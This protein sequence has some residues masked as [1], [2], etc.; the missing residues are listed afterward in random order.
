MIWGG[1]SA[2]GMTELAILDGKQDS[3]KYIFTLCEYL[4]PFAHHLYGCDFV[5]QQD[6]VS[7]HT[8]NVSIAF[9]E[10]M[11][12][13]VMNWPAKSP[14][15]NPRE[16]VWGCLARA[17]YANGRQFST[18]DE[19]KSEIFIQWKNWDKILLKNLIKSMKHRCIQVIERKGNKISY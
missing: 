12:I 17:V 9:F 8:S 14:D 13:D 2:D 18:I 7:V 1:F 11:N 15:L 10:E 6:N 3:E 4:L 16:N 5:F 19:L